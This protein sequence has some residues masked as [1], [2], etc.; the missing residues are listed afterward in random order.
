MAAKRYA[1][2]IKIID[3]HKQKMASE[4][5]KLQMTRND[6]LSRYYTDYQKQKCL[7]DA[8][9][10]L[11]YIS[12]SLAMD[13]KELWTSYLNWLKTLL[14]TQGVKAADVVEHFLILSEVLEDYLPQTDLPRIAELIELAVKVFHD[15]EVELKQGLNK[16]SPRYEEAKKYMN[17]LLSSKRNQAIQ[18]IMSLATDSQAIREIYLHILQPVQREIGFLWHTNKISV[19][20]EHYCTGVTQLVIAQFYPIIFASGN[21]DLKMVSTCVSGELHEIGLRMVTDIMEIDGWDTVYL[22]AN[23]PNSGILETIAREKADLVAISVTY[24]L[25]LHKAEDLIR[26]IKEDADASK[27]KIMVGGYPFL[28][29]VN[30]WQKIGAD[31]FANDASLA[32]GI[33]RRLV[34]A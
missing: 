7:Q 14:I 11:E 8:L 20:Q 12:E 2:S 9:Y 27:A 16:D 32:D 31:A 18:Y 34:K 17:M 10:N 13:S 25:N 6:R 19:A 26:L 22:G 33:A 4:I 3:E 23:M 29:D 15:Q 1:E 30:L 24:P 5:F 21:K 28:S